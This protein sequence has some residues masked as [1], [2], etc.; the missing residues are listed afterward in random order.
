MSFIPLTMTPPKATRLFVALVLLEILFVVIYIA[1][2]PSDLFPSG[3]YKL[4]DLDR[5]NNIPALFSALQLSAIG[6]V[7]LLTVFLQHP[8]AAHP[9]GSLLGLMGLIF[10]FLSV[11]EAVGIHEQMT[12]ILRQSDWIPR[13]GFR[14]DKGM[15]V[16]PY[17]FT[18]MVTAIIIYRLKYEDLILIWK[19]YR[20]E[21]IIAMAGGGLLL[22]GAVGLEVISYQFLREDKLSLVY[23]GEVAAEEFLEMVGASMI[24]YAVINFSFKETQERIPEDL[25]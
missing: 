8:S 1:A 22:T 5:E 10:L 14:G 3:T 21:S 19:L 24:L 13:Y 15:W 7:F 9:S 20:R 25:P 12:K 23:R 17:L 11:D 16:F 6:G 2:I 18:G 4:F